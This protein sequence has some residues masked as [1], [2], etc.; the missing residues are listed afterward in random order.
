MAAENDLSAAP[1]AARNPFV[2][3]DVWRAAESAERDV[4][5]AQR[6]NRARQRRPTSPASANSISTLSGEA[7]TYLL[8]VVVVALLNWFWA[9]V[10]CSESMAVIRRDVQRALFQLGRGP[11]TPARS[12]PPT[13][14]RSPRQTTAEAHAFRP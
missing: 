5:L 14:P 1:A 11:S 7:F 4:A 2:S 13:T 8:C 3:P 12:P 10:C 6:T 9:T